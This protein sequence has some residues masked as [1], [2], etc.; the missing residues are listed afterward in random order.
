MPVMLFM[1]LDEEKSCHALKAAW[2]RNTAASTI[3]RARFAGA[4]GSPRGFH[5]TKT[6]TLP[7]SRI[8]PNPPKKYPNSFAAS[9]DGGGDGTFRPNSA[10]FSLTPAAERPDCTD[11]FKRVHTSS[12]PIVCQSRFP[13]STSHEQ[14]FQHDVVARGQ[15][16]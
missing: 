8:D 3:P 10:A 1:T 15:K 13:T 2:I 12:A 16:E 9:R 6:R 4:G 7:M 5:E 11:V 14:V